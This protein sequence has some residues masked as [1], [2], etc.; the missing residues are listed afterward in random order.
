MLRLKGRELV[1]VLRVADGQLSPFGEDAVCFGGGTALEFGLDEPGQGRPVVLLEDEVDAQ[2][3]EILR[4]EEEAVYVE[5][6]GSDRRE[7]VV[8]F[9]FFLTL[10]AT[11]LAF[12]AFVISC[13]FFS[14]SP[15]S[16]VVCSWV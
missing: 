8:D 16:L 3:V 11:F 5:E 10:L 4:V 6:A 1:L 15:P 9:L 14:L 13:P 2:R 12:S 7:A